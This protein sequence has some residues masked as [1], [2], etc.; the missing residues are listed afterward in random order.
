[1]SNLF[2]SANYPEG[3][4]DELVIGD[5]WLW[6]RTDLGSDYPVAS[7]ALSYSFRMEGNGAQNFDIT[8]SESGSDYLVEVASTTT[9]KYVVGR[10]HWEMYINRS[11]DS[12]RIALG[13]GEVEV[14]PD[15][16]KSSDD[17][18]THA[19][20]M[21]DLLEAYFAANIDRSALSYSITNDVGSR[22]LSRKS[23]EELTAI[24]HF[25]RN[26]R[27]TERAI[28]RRKRGQGTGFRVRARF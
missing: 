5:R 22:S 18:R 6:K 15:R 7:Y 8:A 9:A 27:T 1:M 3:V 16:S 23:D 11:S 28:A 10:Y 26:K 19:A 24:Y 13:T 4:P 25:Y 2:D 12:E 17:P 14:L 20:K 21:C